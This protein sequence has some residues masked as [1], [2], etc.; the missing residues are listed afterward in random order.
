M[1]KFS[2]LSKGTL[3]RMDDVAENMNWHIMNKIEILFDKY[4]IK[5]V[6]G[7]IPNNKDPE[8]LKFPK[9]ENFWEK[10]KTWQKKGWEISMH[11]YSHEYEIETKKKD[12]FKLG[13]KSEF[14]GKSLQDQI[15]K[16]RDGLEIFSSKKIFV[17]SFF[18]PNHTYDNNTFLALK[19]CGINIVIDGYGIGPYKEDQLTFIPQLF[20]RLLA[21]P[22]SYQTTQLHINS[23]NEKD[24]HY[25]EKYISKNQK[26]IIT[27]NQI[28]E[29]KSENFAVS[30]INK[31][32]KNF[33]IFFRSLK[34]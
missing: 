17:R 32:I 27:F 23:W 1:I 25:F 33:L 18:A 21:L 19:K 9:E 20:Y 8:L 13:G 30:L 24:Y 5:P 11:G 10:I 12:F 28:L 3:L 29:K 34:N 14:F 15:H 4:N 31:M 7:V 26:K 22:F 6:I 16:V 2:S